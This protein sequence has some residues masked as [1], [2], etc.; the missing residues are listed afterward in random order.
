MSREYKRIGIA[1]WG[2]YCAY[3]LVRDQR[4]MPILKST[5]RLVIDGIKNH[6]GA[7]PVEGYVNDEERHFLVSGEEIVQ[8]NSKGVPTTFFKV[9]TVH[10]ILAPTTIKNID[11]QNGTIEIEYQ[12]HDIQSEHAGSRKR[13]YSYFSG[14]GGLKTTQ[15]TFD[16][17]CSYSYNTMKDYWET[18]VSSISIDDILKEFKK[19]NNSW[20]ITKT[21]F[22]YDKVRIT[23]F[24][25]GLNEEK[26]ETCFYNF[27][28][29]LEDKNVLLS[30]Q[31]SLGVLEHQARL[32]DYDFSNI[33]NDKIVETKYNK[34]P[35]E[36]EEVSIDGLVLGTIIT[37]KNIVG[38]KKILELD[39]VIRGNESEFEYAPNYKA[40]LVGN[41]LTEMLAKQIF[42]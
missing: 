7:F 41:D 8:N 17:S 29:F 27:I 12:Y 35:S 14:Y 1:K 19:L 21:S 38:T 9:E 5:E 34:N 26:V 37:T 6:C 31:T 33:K 16:L 4:W 42:Q 22:S 40:V 28:R 24:N 25:K 13:G 23:L 32:S 15:K 3:D 18:I 20:V 30:I 11:Y 39:G 2:G 36:S 10:P